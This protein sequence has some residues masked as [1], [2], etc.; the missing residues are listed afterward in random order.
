MLR[1][2]ADPAAIWKLGDEVKVG[3]VR[4]FVIIAS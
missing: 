2:R 3:P 1:D 4:G